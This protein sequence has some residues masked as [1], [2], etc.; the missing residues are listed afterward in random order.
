MK[1]I[2]VGIDVS[3]GQLVSSINQA[4]P[5]ELAN[6]HQGALTLASQLPKGSIVH[7]EA[8]GG[9]ER[10]ARR[11]L[12]ESGFTVRVHNPC[13]ARRMNQALSVRAK[14]DPVDAVSLSRSGHLLPER[15]PKSIEREMLADHSRAI[16]A[17]SGTI[18][19]F[20]RRLNQPALDDV[21]ATAYLKAVEELTQIKE[22][23]KRSFAQRILSSSLREQYKLAQSLPGVG[24]YTA[25]RVLV[26]LPENY[27]EVDPDMIASYAG[28]APMDHSS[29]KYKGTARVGMGNPHLKGALFMG[30]Q[31][32][33]ARDP[34]LRAKY[35]RLR[36]R[37]HAH[38]KAMVAL[39]R[40]R[41]TLLIRVLQ[42]GTPWQ[43]EPPTR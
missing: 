43:K 27:L 21:A 39:M 33:L 29:G 11:T 12:I 8:T 42:R 31:S 38:Q 5:F 40:H 3:K 37:G 6:T 7:L 41:M 26:E 25:A 22:E 19:D 10:Q 20:K 17:I 15:T 35:R 24:P 2:Q 28:L 23:L 32:L 9:F 36:E 16:E 18:A 1:S 14:T 34:E 13:N 30:T 4:K